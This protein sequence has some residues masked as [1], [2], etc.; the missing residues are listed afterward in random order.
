L[1]HLNKKEKMDIKQQL[2]KDF[3]VDLPIHGGFGN[4]I[5]NAVVI[6]RRGLN[7]YVSVEYSFLRCIGRGRGIEWKLL[8]Q[9]LVH[10]DGR[11]YDKMK[12]ETTELTPTEVITT[13]ENYY[14]DITDCFGK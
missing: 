10:Q 11:T 7:D 14:F 8:N 6:N 4:S 9:Q 2:L 1:L 12:I 5:E 13:I 3:G